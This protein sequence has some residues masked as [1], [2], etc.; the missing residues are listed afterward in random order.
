MAKKKQTVQNYDFGKARIEKIHFTGELMKIGFSVETPNS[1]RAHFTLKSEDQPHPDFAKSLI[2]LRDDIAK[3]VTVSHSKQT[4]IVIHEIHLKHVEE[5]IGFKVVAY[6]ANPNA[7]S[8]LQLK[9]PLKWIEHADDK[10][11]LDEDV[12]ERLNEAVYE[13]AQYINGKRSQQSLFVNEGG[14]LE[15]IEAEPEPVEA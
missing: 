11:K 4:E 6:R 15:S 2:N 13:A 10:Q 8:P 12:V 3:W 7:R 9:C 14:Q 5:N 1:K